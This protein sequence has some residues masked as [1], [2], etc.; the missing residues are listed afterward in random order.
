M[1]R[2]LVLFLLYSGVTQVLGT[3]CHALIFKN[4]CAEEVVQLGDARRWG[5]APQPSAAAP[6]RAVA[7]VR[8]KLCRRREVRQEELLVAGSA[9]ELSLQIPDA[10]KQR[11]H[12]R[13]ESSV[14]LEGRSS[15]GD[16]GIPSVLRVSEGRVGCSPAG[17]ALV[18]QN[19]AAQTLVSWVAQDRLCKFSLGSAKRVSAESNGTQA[20]P[21]RAGSVP[22]ECLLHQVLSRS[23]AVWA[24]V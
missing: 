23:V 11:F 1:V 5:P 12:A 14:R 8:D 20:A 18:K 16:S 24:A 10:Y 2:W 22:A 4:D 17:I 13:S 7:G 3:A 19:R 15:R 21:G 6:C 9:D